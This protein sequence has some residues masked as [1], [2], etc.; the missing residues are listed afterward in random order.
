MPDSSSKS[1]SPRQPS[2]RPPFRR[3]WPGIRFSSWNAGFQLEKRDWPGIRFSSWNA[4]ISKSGSPRQPSSRP[5][6]RRDWPGIRF[7]RIR[8]SSSKSG[9]PRQPSSRPP[10]RRDWP[11]IF[12]SWNAGFQ[13]E[14]RGIGRGSAFRAGMPD[15]SSK[16]G[17]PRQPS[18]RP[19]FRR[20]WPGI[21]FSSWIPDSSWKSGSPRQ[22]SS[23]P[24]FRRDWPGIRFSSWNAGFQLEK[25]I[26]KTTFITAPFQ[27][28]LAGDPLFEL[29]CRIPARKADPQDN[30]HH[31][32]LSGEICPDW[33]GIRFSSWNAGF[34]LEKRIPKTTFITAPFQDGLAGDP[35]FK[36]ECRKRGIGR[37]SAF[38][39]GMPD[40]SS[41]SG[42]PRQPSS[43]P[44]DWPGIRF[45][46]WNAGFQLEKR[47]PKTTFITAP[48]QDGLAG[49]P[50][51]KLECRKRGIGRGSAFRAG[52]P[53]SSSKSGS[54]RQPSSRPPDWPG[55][56]FSSWNAGFQLKKRIPKTTFITAPFQEGLAGD[57]LFELE[58]RIPARKAR[59]WPGI[60]FS[61]WNAG[62]Q[63]EK[64]I[65]KTTFITPPF[66][67]DWPG[68]RFSSWNAGFQLEKRIPKTTF[69]TAPFQEGL[70]GDPLFELECRIPARKAD[71]QDNLHHGP[72]S[73]GIGRGS[74]FRA[75]MPDSSSKSGSPRQPSSRPLSGGIG[76]GSAFRAG[77]PD[78]SSKSGS[79]RQ[80]S[81]R[82]PFRRDWPGI[83]FS[84][85]NAGFQLEK[86]IPKTTFITAPFQEGLAGDP[87]SELECRI[88]ARKADPQDNL[89]HGP[90]SGGI[91]RGS[92]FRAGMPDSS[93]K[94]GFPR[95]PSSRPPFRRDWPGIRFSSWNAGFQLEKRI[96]NTTFITAPFQEGLAGDPLFELECRIP[97]QKADPQDNLHHGPLSGGIGPGSA[98]RAGMPDSSSKADPQDNLHHGPLFRGI[99][100]G[101][102][103]RA[104]MPDSSSKSEG[105]G[106]GSAFRA[107]MPDSS[108]KS[109]S[110][111]QPSSRPPFRRDWP[112]IRF[113]SWNAGFQLEKRIS[114]TT[115]ITA[116]FQ[117]GL[118]GIRFS[119][120]N[121]GFQL[122]KRIPKTTFITAP[123]SGGIGRGSAFRAGMPDS[124]SKSGSPRQPSS[125]PPFRR[126]WPGIR[127]SSWNA[128]FQLEKRIPKTTFITAPLSGGI[129]RGSAF[130]AGMPDSSSKSGS[131]RQPSSRPP[132]RRDWLGIRFRAGMPDS[133]SKSGSPRQPSSR[134]PFRRD[135]PGI[136]FSS[137]PLS[138]G[139][140]WGSA[141]RAG[142]PDSSS[143]SGSPR[144][145]SS[146]PPFRRDWPGIRFA[147]WNA[148]RQLEK[149]IPKTTFITA[150]FQEGLAGDPLFELESSGG[151]GRGSA[152]RAGM[153]DSS[154]KSG[155]P[156]QPSSR[157]PF[158]RDWP[159]IRFS[160]WN[161]GFQLEKRIPKT[162]FI[163]APFQEGLAGDPLFELECRIPARKAD[164]Q[165][166]L[167]HGPPFRRDWP[168]IR[169][170]S[171]NAGFQLEKR[172]PKTTFITA[173]FQEGLA[174]D[175]LFELE[176]RIPARKADPQDNLHH[177]PLSGGIGRGSA[178]R[179]GMPDSSSKSGSPRQPSSRPPFRRDW[180]GIRFSSWNAG[181]QLEK[182]IPKTTFITAP[183]QEGLAGDPLFE[184]DCKSGS[185][186]QPSSRPPFRR[187]WP[188]IRFSSWIAGFQ[189][190]KRIPKTTF[191][192]APFQEGL[193]GD[194][195][196]E[197]ECRTPARKADPQDNLHHGPLSGGIGW[198]SAFRAGM[199]DSS[200]KSGSPFRRGPFFPQRLC[201]VFPHICFFFS[202]SAG[203][204]PFYARSAKP[205]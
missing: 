5:P 127:F 137:C 23:R 171:W 121:A 83:R 93:S 128:G 91:G 162:T 68:I 74:A 38:R 41:K 174:G 155:P 198:G 149:R 195:L 193:A 165:D 182:R 24:P 86:W 123:L 203:F 11:G 17:S 147:S 179:A 119:S 67:R 37:G 76:R 21:R 114:K 56:R 120:W 49:D 95:Q 85:W 177:G 134:P 189:L 82:P 111:R 151:I 122:E 4:G 1:G 12:S 89:H 178:F 150:P 176:C 142:M 126:D 6:F 32:P 138:G 109:G 59:D 61:S 99:N 131:P 42:S 167:H 13:L 197:L 117:E 196:F 139:I 116:P 199:P 92:A 52:M 71:P 96:P 140:G 81:S 159:G 181:F 70:A 19:P 16:S 164:P 57:P 98:F 75:G 31:G 20:D 190:E 10:F 3:D 148:G 88:P 201:F 154:S 64:R 66:R 200:S 113:S 194:P 130:R 53:D 44:P 144:Q 30:L 173:P 115:F 185:P 172:I 133:S 73:G 45:S 168:G 100:R 132:F 106:R 39:A 163:T 78:S 60:R 118:P 183:F 65:P 153:P 69:I 110:P 146:R 7:S 169:F 72:L 112:G 14:K 2:S 97:A 87:L 108:S 129:G 145:P 191:I 50:L 180:L 18:S 158:R 84:S 40:S 107:G 22:P 187:D 28:G 102:P 105:I 188:G 58:C 8:H 141:F 34:Q 101:S 124:S 175:P 36:L 35:L 103:F 170:S 90:L 161:A 94:S 29:E 104:G 125:R 51:F 166:N 204:P 46:S 192:T 27:E 15:S 184:L 202:R 9:S 157:P 55:I 135:W 152:F 79:A 47:I 205:H 62:F 63:L 54:P 25:R 160:S 80:P 48:F 156:R 33:P 143:K 43:R 186:R 136:R 77:M 26:P